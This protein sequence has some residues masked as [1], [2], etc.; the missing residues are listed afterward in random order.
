MSNLKEL[1][2]FSSESVSEGHPDKI[3]DQVSDAI[4]DACLKQDPNSRVAC[5]T[6]ATAYKMIIS[7]EIRTNAV[8]DYAKVAR[9]VLTH[10]GY[11]SKNGLDPETYP[12]EILINNQ[13]QDIAQGVDHSSD[14]QKLI[15]A[16]D[17]GIMFGY[18]TDETDSYMPLALTIAHDLVKTAS[19]LRKSNDF[20]YAGPDMKSEVTLNYS[21]PQEVKIYSV[22][23][24]IQH[25]DKIDL[26]VFY[27]YI[28]ESII[29][30]VVEK[31]LKNQKEF[32]ILINPTGR[33]VIGG[34]VGDTGLT[35]RK[36]IV[37]TYGGSARHGGGAFSGKDATKV[38]RSGAYITRYIAKNIVAAKLAK[39]IEIQLSYAIGVSE[40]ISIWVNTQGTSQYDDN[41]I[42]KVIKNTFNLTP[43]GIIADL[44]LQK[45]W[46]FKVSAYGHFGRDDI[47]NLPWEKLDKVSEIKK[48]L[49]IILQK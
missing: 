13:S 19:K 3:C 21:D 24:S 15:G 11:S 34:P 37:D 32:K 33:F 2:L 10:I 39:Q 44:E 20:K 31:H 36:I 25:E 14:H 23:M 41:V 46:Y 18:A 38:D 12:I 26:E 35:G 17:Q 1:I 47:P 43:S 40:P 28:K 48:H 30:P 42:I 49:Q 27:N 9:Q 29:K 7:V 16:G 8:V 4:L 45:P 22:L 5:E 6:F